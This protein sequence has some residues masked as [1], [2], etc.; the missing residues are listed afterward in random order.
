MNG[1]RRTLFVVICIASPALARAEEYRLKFVPNPDPKEVIS[2]LQWDEGKDTQEPILQ[3]REKEKEGLTYFVK[4]QGRFLQKDRVLLFESQTVAL[5]SEGKFTIN[6]GIDSERQEFT[7]SEVKESG[8]IAT[9]KSEILF[10]EWK[11]YLESQSKKPDPEPKKKLSFQAGLGVAAITYSQTGVGSSPTGTFAE[12]GL[13]LKGGVRYQWK[14][15]LAFS[16]KSSFTLLPIAIGP[17][18]STIRFL[19]LR[20]EVIYPFPFIHTPWKLELLGNYSYLTAFPSPSKFGYAIVQGISLYP[21]LERELSGEKKLWASVRFTPISAGGITFLSP[22]SYEFN[23]QA[24]YQ[25][26][27]LKSHW[28]DLTLDVNLFSLQFSAGSTGSIQSNSYTVGAN[29]LF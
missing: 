11:G 13:D 20:A 19:N 25:G 14:D 7:I 6:V 16:G 8:D 28:I 24:G 27:K 12:L 3:T 17:T 10:P 29:Y 2:D 18:G 21:K 23:F 9:Q 5:G 1:W 26:I 15:Y 22:S 4:L